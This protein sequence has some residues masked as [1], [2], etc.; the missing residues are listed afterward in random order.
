MCNKAR[1]YGLSV[2]AAVAVLTLCAGVGMSGSA[3]A[4]FSSSR[5]VEG[6][7]YNPHTKSYFEL[8]YSRQDR[9]WRNASRWA[10]TLSYKGVQGRLAIVRS[11]ET[12]DFLLTRF[13]LESNEAWIG[14][15]LNCDS[16]KL[17]WVD[18]SVL[19]SDGFSVWDLQQWHRTRI[20]CGHNEILHMGV[21][22]RPRE[23]YFRWQAAGENK[24]FNRYF[25]EYPTGGP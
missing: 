9:N 8:Q 11:V 4:Q 24:A 5:T 15:R 3:Q 22:Y 25:I 19:E 18:G 1:M 20:R 12:H 16:G 14:L 13:H 17:I 21:Y 2:A 6:P 10:S 7:I 23:K